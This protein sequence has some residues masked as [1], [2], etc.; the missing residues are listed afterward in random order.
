MG[1][2]VAQRAAGGVVG[3][4]VLQGRWR[5]RRRRAVG[6]DATAAMGPVSRAVRQPQRENV[7]HVL[8][9]RDFPLNTVQDAVGYTTSA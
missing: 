7:G 6:R 3:D 2:Q 1:E 5:G 8:H 9:R 4:T